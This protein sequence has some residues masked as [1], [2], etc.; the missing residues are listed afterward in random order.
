[1]RADASPTVLDAMAGWG[2]DA[3]VLTSRGCRVTPIERHPALAAL[4]EDLARRSGNLDVACRVGDGFAAL[5]AGPFDVIYLDPMFPVRGKDALPGRRLQWLAE[6]ASP[7][8]RP[9]TAWLD[10]AVAQ[11]RRRV[12]L[13]RRRRDPLVR[14]PD[15]QILGRTV[16]YDVFRGTGGSWPVT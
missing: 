12:V 6:L 8:P 1:V 3:L 13:K 16:R 5:A 2:V 9:L 11:A 4:A 14:A 7:D 15:W 10:E